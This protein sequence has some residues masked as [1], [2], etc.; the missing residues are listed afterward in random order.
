MYIL[1]FILGF[2]FG[3]LGVIVIYY[4]GSIMVFKDKVDGYTM[5]LNVVDSK[6][7]SK[8][9]IIVLSVKDCAK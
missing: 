3:L 8:Q 4:N 1:A 9:K 5:T 7:L 6:R 2:I